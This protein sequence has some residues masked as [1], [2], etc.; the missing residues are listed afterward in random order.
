MNKYHQEIFLEIKEVSE[1]NSKNTGWEHA[2]KYMG[3]TKTIHNITNPQTHAIAKNWA[4][5]HKNLTV[6]ELSEILNAFFAGQSHNERSFGGKLLGYYP[7]LQCQ[8][9]PVLLDKWL[10]GA[11]GWGEVDSIC[12]N[13]FQA[14][15]MLED[16]KDWEKWLRTWSKD[17][18]VHKRRASLV[19]L[20]GP[21]VY[22]ND[23]R[24]FDLAFENIDQLM[25]EKDI[26][27]TK[28]VSWL[29]RSIVRRHPELVKDYLAKN[30]NSL[31]KIA[32]RETRN[33]LKSGRKS[34]K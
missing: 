6:S 25:G 15:E 7:K 3:T 19:L 13:V 33:K 30:E 31:P 5:Q 22:S 2:G 21:V 10:N 24:L 9:K 16:W 17:K 11:E 8:L 34:G 29:L 27:I 14:K 28:A 26:L 20:T 1:T 32:V 4:R 23:Q 12:Q 18:N